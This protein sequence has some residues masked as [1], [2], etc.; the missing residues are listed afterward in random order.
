LGTLAF[1][2]RDASFEEDLEVSVSA[3]LGDE[4]AFINLLL[5]S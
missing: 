4:F 1:V 5:Q 3:P 2:F